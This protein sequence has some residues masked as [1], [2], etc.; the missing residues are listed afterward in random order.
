MAI[1]NPARARIVTA[2]TVAVGLLAGVSAVAQTPPPA[3]AIE[4]NVKAVFLFNFAK[5]VTWPPIA[6]GER[7]PA[8]VRICVTA[9]NAFFGLLKAAVKGEDVEGKPLVAVALDGLD[10]AR[11]CQILYVGDSRSAEARAWFGAVRNAQVLTVA[12]DA[13]TDDTVIAFVRDDNRIRFDINR[14]AA[15]RYSLNISSKLLRLARRV[16]ER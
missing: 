6:I 11:A 13:L 7:S 14:A 2:M 5:Y 8:E 1:L 12:D 16:K 4:A 9:N 10:E 3:P 15:S